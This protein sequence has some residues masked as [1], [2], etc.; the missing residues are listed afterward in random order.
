MLVIEGGGPEKQDRGLYY[1]VLC[2]G[3]LGGR[4][5]IYV[6]YLFTADLV[7]WMMPACMSPGNPTINLWW[8]KW[9]GRTKDRGVEFHLWGSRNLAMQR[10]VWRPW[11]RLHNLLPTLWKYLKSQSLRYH[12]ILV[13]LQRMHPCSRTDAPMFQDRPPLM[14]VAGTRF[15]DFIYLFLSCRCLI[16][17]I[18]SLY[19]T[20]A[21]IEA[22]T[23]LLVAYTC[24]FLCRM[25]QEFGIG[26]Y[27]WLGLNCSHDSFVNGGF[28][29]C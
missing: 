15:W 18:Y 3:F 22:R 5:I 11:A 6:P 26:A 10:K 27:I 17:F 23:F 21:S 14:F 4:S 25:E 8:R 1:S 13:D 20:L 28:P 19:S 7:R 29:V 9:R 16:T 24:S 2:N 12:A